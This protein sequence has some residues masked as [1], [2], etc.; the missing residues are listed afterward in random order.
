MWPVIPETIDPVAYYLLIGASV[1]VVGIAKAGF[2]G[3]IGI[4]AI[5]LMAAAMGAQ[6]MLG[7]MLPLLIACDIFSNLHYMGERDWSRLRNLLIGATFGIAVG[8]GVLF[9][10]A[11]MPPPQFGRVMTG[12]VGFICLAVVLLQVY[13]MTGREVPTLPPHPLSAMTVG[14]LAGALS[15]L[16]HAAG[17]IIMI[18][19]LHEGIQKRRLVGTMLMYFLI[20]NTLKL[21]TYLLLEMPDGRPLINLDTLRDS[22]WFIPLIPIGT[23]AGA[24]MNKRID[25]RPFAAIMYIFAA[26]SAVHMIYKALA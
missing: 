19:L 26:I 9:Y 20:G 3:G 7:V 25:E 21:P 1:L 24:W 8:T 18:Y 14:L 16:N 4:L 6:H 5:P 10:L 23:L 17:P 22:I 12:L 13:R 11:G 2:G 15:T